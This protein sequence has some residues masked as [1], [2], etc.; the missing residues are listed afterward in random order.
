[1]HESRP[2]R[3]HARDRTRSMHACMPGH[4]GALVAECEFPFSPSIHAKENVPQTRSLLSDESDKNP[5]TRPLTTCASPSRILA[6]SLR[7]A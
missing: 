4:G 6:I 1:M 7:F 2:G 3:C 5:H